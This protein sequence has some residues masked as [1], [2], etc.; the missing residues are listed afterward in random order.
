M[1]QRLK[2][3]PTPG[4]KKRHA[5]KACPDTSLDLQ[6]SVEIRRPTMLDFSDSATRGTGIW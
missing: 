1:T 4:V 6:E 2:P 3:G 5:M